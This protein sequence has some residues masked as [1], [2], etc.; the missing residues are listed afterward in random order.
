MKLG[1]QVG[2]GPGHHIVLN[3]DPTPPKKGAQP[4]IF[5]PCLLWPNGWMDQDATWYGGRPGDIAL[6]G[7]SAPH[8]GAHTP[9]FRPVSIV[10]KRSPIS[11]TAEH[12]FVLL[13]SQQQGCSRESEIVFVSYLFAIN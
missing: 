6:D 12:L 5:G 3:G 11:A 8:K 7:D 4:P 2:L 10:T 9:N 1:T 13:F